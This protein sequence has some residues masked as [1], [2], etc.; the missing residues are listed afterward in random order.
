MKTQFSDS[1]TAP[2]KIK[3]KKF[4]SSIKFKSYHQ[5]CMYAWMEKKTQG[6]IPVMGGKSNEY[7]E[8]IFS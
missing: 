5:I 2:D 3:E 6:T 7:S 1:M 8:I 4:L